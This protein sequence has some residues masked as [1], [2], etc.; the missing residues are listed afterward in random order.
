MASVDQKAA[1]Q[2]DSFLHPGEQAVKVLMPQVRPVFQRRGLT[3]V[4]MDALYAAHPT[5]W[6]NQAG[7]PKSVR[8]SGRPSGSIR[9]EISGSGAILIP[10]RRRARF[11]WS[12]GSTFLAMPVEYLS[13]EQEARYGRF[14]TEPSPGELE[15]FFRLATRALE[16]ARAKRRSAT[17]LGWAVQWGTVRMLSTFLTEDPTAVPASAVRFV[18]EQLGLD[19]EHFAEYGTRAQTVYEHAWEIRDT[20]GYRDFAAGEAELREFLAARVW[21]SS[22]EGPRAL[23]DRAVVRLVNNR[24]LPGVTSLARMVAALRQEENDRLHAALYE[25]VPYELRTEMVRLLE[26]PEKKRVSELE[27]LRLGPMR[28]S[29]KAME[30]ALDGAREV[31][32][33]GAGAVDAGRVPAA[34][35][36]G[37]ARYGLTSKA[38]TLKRLEVTRQTATLLATVR[39]LETATVDDALDLLHALMAT[40]LLAKAER[41]GNDAKLKALPQSRKAAKKVAAAVDVLMTTPPATDTGE[42]VSVVDAW[43][44]IEQVVPREQLAEALATIASMVPDTDGDD[45]AE[46]RAEL[47]ARYGTV[48]ASSASWSRSSTSAP[49][50]PAPPS[51]RPSSGSRI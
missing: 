10:V 14:A 41:M 11:A 6:I 42:L 29:G 24:V 16:L 44:A 31:R 3:G 21:S 34:R 23:F 8:S 36:T 5:A 33:L 4:L 43:S 51:F 2:L 26:V 32:G 30:L 15:Q 47:V 35:M 13:A 22:L 37:L 39:H 46:W 38:P 19:D 48:V 9:T 40:K 49:S 1:G 28:V 17:R 50:K 27:R 7:A 45:D 12:T 18:A 20:Y 25:V